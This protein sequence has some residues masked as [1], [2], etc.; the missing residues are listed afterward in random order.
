MKKKAL[1]LL[2][3][4]IMG[5]AG[6]QGPVSDAMQTPAVSSTAA[7]SAPP[8]AVP[9]TQDSNQ[10]GYVTID[11]LGYQ[12][13]GVR[14]SENDQLTPIWREK[15][16]V[17]MEL[18]PIDEYES[19]LS[20]LEKALASDSLPSVIALEEG[21]FDV[22]S[23]YEFLKSEDLLLP[24]DYELVEQY[25][26]LT[27]QRLESMGISLRDWYDAN[28][29]LDTG[30]W[31]YIPQLPSGLL[32]ESLRQTRYGVDQ[33][34]IALSYLWIR[35]DVLSQFS[36]NAVTA[37]TLESLY[38]IY[39]DY[40]TTLH[41]CDS[42]LDTLDALTSLFQMISESD[43]T[44]G[45]VYASPLFDAS[46]GSVIWSLYGA[47]GYCW[48]DLPEFP[49]NLLSGG[50]DFSYYALTD[51]WKTYLK[52]LNNCF[53]AGYL[54]DDYFTLSDSARAANIQS[55]RYAV[56]NGY[57]TLPSYSSQADREYGWRL[58]PVF[59]GNAQNSQQDNQTV[60]LSLRTDG[61]VGFNREEVT[62]EML[63][64][65][66]GWVDW[67]YSLE[68]AYL[69]AWGDGLSEETE[70]GR[71][72]SADYALVED[73]MLNGYIGES[74]E[75]DGWYYGLVNTLSGTRE[76]WNHEVYGIG[77][78]D[79]G[80][81]CPYYTYPLFQIDYDALQFVPFVIKKTLI[82]ET[83]NMRY[84]VLPFD[85]SF[86]ALSQQFES[87]LASY[88]Q[89]YAQQVTAVSNEALM[90]AVQ[91]EPSDFESKYLEYID[92][93]LQSG[94]DSYEQEIR[95]LLEQMA[96]QIHS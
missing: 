34:P 37:N 68:A 93:Y 90:A 33:T 6:C 94:L 62:E 57:S 67:N 10:D 16:G 24:I 31:L 43:A 15:T 80:P 72:F 5:V 20:Y 56:L 64:Q 79:P 78:S 58:Y 89:A 86:L 19:T 36:N 11:V 69:R 12:Q 41:V 8:S 59:L 54:G 14:K 39:A 76:V 73:T 32:D 47:S 70:E 18:V 77:S 63:G 66:L 27:A 84:V 60:Y 83:L 74:G 61:A 81:D 65:L 7:V 49:N 51:G 25:M 91:C 71:R 29:D 75:E 21:V 92:V 23:C 50:D 40:A 1:V 26:P 44:F 52:W 82:T 46:A 35:D 4:L 48:T 96:E 30:K 9:D 55:G 95:A 13:T 53:N 38:S 22:A 85:E 3:A 17:K 88:K 2:L 87:T 28:I 45:E 42:S